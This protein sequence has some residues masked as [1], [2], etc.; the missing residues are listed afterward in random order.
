MELSETQ[1]K[2]NFSKKIR[3]SAAGDYFFGLSGFW[4]G[5]DV[6]SWKDRVLVGGIDSIPIDFHS[7]AS[8]SEVNHLTEVLVQ[9]F[10]RNRLVLTR[11]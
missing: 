1:I 9:R 2:W 3:S 4:I 8:H 11:V 6:L 5:H 7:D 10:T